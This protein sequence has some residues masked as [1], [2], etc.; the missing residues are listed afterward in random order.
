MQDKKS[1]FSFGAMSLAIVAVVCGALGYAVSRWYFGEPA[2]LEPA[3]Q[4]QPQESVASGARP[5]VD[6]GLLGSP[7]PPFTLKDLES[8]EQ[9]SGQWKGKVLLINFWATWCP[10]CLEEMPGFIELQETYASRGFQVLGIAIDEL[11]AVKSFRDTLGVN[12]PILIGDSDAIALSSNLGNHF[13]ALPYSLLVDRDGRI[14]Y[15]RPGALPKAAL[16]AELSK[17]L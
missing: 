15:I 5:A 6:P 10:P 17:L 2:P 11:Q 8:K 1:A 7:L 9:H 4:I 16:D 3:S 12:Y 13:G 14:R